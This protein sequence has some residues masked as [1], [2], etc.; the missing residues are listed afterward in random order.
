[1]AKVED[2]SMQPDWARRVQHSVR[3]YAHDV[4]EFVGQIL[5]YIPGVAPGEYRVHVTL[6]IEKLKE[7]GAVES[8][9]VCEKSAPVI[10]PPPWGALH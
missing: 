2:D 6:R 3:K 1:M 10:V 5:Q 9:F 7:D 8:S 4:F